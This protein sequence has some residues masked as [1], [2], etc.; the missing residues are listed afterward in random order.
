MLLNL[1]RR[2]LA[3]LLAVWLGGCTMLSD[4]PMR[5]AGKPEETARPIRSYAELIGGFD[6]TLTEAER[7]A[8]I[9]GL[10]REKQRQAGMYSESE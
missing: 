7:K 5:M 4:Q 9:H 8:V 2:V 6:R 1:T 10:Q 3:M